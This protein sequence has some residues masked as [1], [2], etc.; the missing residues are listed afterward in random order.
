MSQDRGSSSLTVPW[1]PLGNSSAC[2]VNAGDPEKSAT[3]QHRCLVSEASLNAVL[4]GAIPLST[5][6]PL[7]V[8]SHWLFVD[9]L[10]RD[11]AEVNLYGI[12]AVRL[13]IFYLGTVQGPPARTTVTGTTA[14]R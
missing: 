9:M 1:K 14:K 2:Y 3:V 8:T 13:N 7:E 5:P 11:V 6:Q 10:L 12:V 4:A